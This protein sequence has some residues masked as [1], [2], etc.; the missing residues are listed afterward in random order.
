MRGTIHEFGPAQLRNLIGECCIYIER[1]KWF[2]INCSTG[3]GEVGPAL[4]VAHSARYCASAANLPV[5]VSGFWPAR[6]ITSA[7]SA[8][9]MV[10]LAESGECG[11]VLHLL[12]PTEAENLPFKEL[13]A[14]IPFFTSAPDCDAANSAANRS[15]LRCSMV[16]RVSSA[17]PE[18]CGA[19]KLPMTL[20]FSNAV[21]FSSVT[22]SWVIGLPE[23]AN[24]AAGRKSF[25]LRDRSCRSISLPSVPM[26]S[27]L[28][29]GRAIYDF[30]RSIVSGPRCTW[31]SNGSRSARRVSL[32][33][34]LGVHPL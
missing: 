24:A 14:S 34:C 29:R 2:A 31:H 1:V 28:D 32:G 15:N 20:P 21:P 22:G 11:V 18:I 8:F 16:K 7:R 23:E 4:R 17:F 9:C 27:N 5:A 3:D 30:A 13:R 33:Q 26:R 10:R 6:A 25:R 19:L 12:S